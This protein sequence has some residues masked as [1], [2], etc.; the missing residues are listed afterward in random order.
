MIEVNKYVKEN[1]VCV[2]EYASLDQWRDWRILSRLVESCLG[3][4][5]VLTD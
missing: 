4:G 2:F 5:A 3:R 1:C